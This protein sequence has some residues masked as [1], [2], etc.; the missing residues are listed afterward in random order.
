M[1]NDTGRAA[2]KHLP[3]AIKSREAYELLIEDPKK[4]FLLDVRTVP[5]YELVGHPDIPGGA[6]NIPLVFYPD[7][8]ANENFVSEVEERFDKETAR[9][10]IICRSGVRAE[11]AAALLTQAGFKE[12][13]YVTDSF[14]GESDRSGLR[15][16][17]GWKNEG[18]PYT[19][20]LDE[21]YVY[22]KRQ[23]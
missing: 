23:R 19:Y 13:L 1:N 12:V 18:L 9:L 10:V 5:E 2:L 16:V 7:Y 4:F 22:G 3:E 14:E 6:Y 21:R 8:R 11:T 15:T 17:N 20:Y